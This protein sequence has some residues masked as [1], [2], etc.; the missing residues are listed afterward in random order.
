MM[1]TFNVQITEGIIYDAINGAVKQ[2]LPAL[3]RQIAGVDADDKK[4]GEL[5][6]SSSFGILRNGK[7]L[8]TEKIREVKDKPL[9]R[10]VKYS[11]VVTVGGVTVTIGI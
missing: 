8:T 10:A 4:T 7:P 1:L 2:C 3:A 11:A 6:A 9:T 5:I